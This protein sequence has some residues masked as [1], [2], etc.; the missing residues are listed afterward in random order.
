MQIGREGEGGPKYVYLLH[1]MYN[2]IVI[3][4]YGMY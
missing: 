3:N 1:N 2:I 4:Y